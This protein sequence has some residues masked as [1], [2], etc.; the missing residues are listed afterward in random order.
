MWKTG[1][2]KC[3]RTKFIWAL[4]AWGVAAILVLT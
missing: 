3:L 4:V 1:D 2:R